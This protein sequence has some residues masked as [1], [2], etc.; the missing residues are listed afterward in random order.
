MLPK[1]FHG[2]MKQIIVT[3]VVNFIVIRAGKDEVGELDG[4]RMAG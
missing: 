1:V 3:V 2:D 4:G